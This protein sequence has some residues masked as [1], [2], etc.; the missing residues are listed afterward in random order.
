MARVG[1]TAD[2]G[3]IL[4]SGSRAH[5]GVVAGIVFDLA[6]PFRVEVLAEG[7]MS[8]YRGL[9]DRLFVPHVTGDDAATLP[10]LGGRASFAWRFGGQLVSN[11]KRRWSDLWHFGRR[12][13]ACPCDRTPRRP[14][15]QSRTSVA[16]PSHPDGPTC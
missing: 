5:L 4:L 15:V 12:P 6:A 11:T 2:L 1:I 3:G 9:G 10:Y 14:D 16:R 8:N 13:R 7:G